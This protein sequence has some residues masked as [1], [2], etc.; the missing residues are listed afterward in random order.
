MPADQVL[1]AK[2]TVAVLPFD[3]Q[4]RNPEQDYFSEG[5]TEDIISALGRFSSLAVMSWNAVAP[6]RGKVASPEQLSQELGVRYVVDGSVRRSD[7]RIRVTIQLTDAERG[8][9]L[10][11]ERYDRSLDDIFALQDDITRQIVSALAI[12]VTYLEQEHALAKPTDNLN[13][14]DYYLRARRNFQQFTRSSNLRAR[15]L[16]ERAIELDREYG[17]AY[18]ALAWTYTKSAEL[19]WT[20]WPDRDLARAHELAQAALRLDPANLL[21]HV[22][23]ALVYTYRQSYDRALEE[24]D[25]GTAANPNQVGNNA[26]RGWVELVGGRTD[27]AVTSLEDALRFDPNPIPNTFSNLAMA[28]YLQ[29][30]HDDAIRTAEQ[31]VSRYPYHVML[32]IALAAAYA[33]AG[34]SDS[35][36]HAAAEL[37][38][39]HPFFEVGSFGQFFRN[40]SDRQ[41]FA[42]A[43]RQ[44]GLE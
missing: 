7:D 14:Y 2:P 18:A 31:G 9:L 20:E 4:S 28:Y 1:A 13:A 44:A 21:A 34:R 11:S 42:A 43:L 38:R 15:E 35:A 16:L 26:E 3:N 24:L 33:D 22:L 32:Y 39:L 17:D 40:L 19:G 23:L 30:R 29:G 5:I 41:R 25:R 12:R 27:D 10:W 37:R 36:A 6:Y 8:L